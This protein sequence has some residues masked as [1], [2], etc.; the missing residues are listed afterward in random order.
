MQVNAPASRSR[1]EGSV[2]FTQELFRNSDQLSMVNPVPAPIVIPKPAAENPSNLRVVR[3]GGHGR[4]HQQGHDRNT[5]KPRRQEL[6]EVVEDS[7]EDKPEGAG[8]QVDTVA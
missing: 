1:L 5:R 4:R 6:P 7:G 8:Q 2:F 3:Y